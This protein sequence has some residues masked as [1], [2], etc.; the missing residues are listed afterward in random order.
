M[1]VLLSPTLA[2]LA[3]PAA[4]PAA[5][6]ARAKPSPQQDRVSPVRTQAPAAAVLEYLGRYAEA[7]D[8]LDPLGFAED[9]DPP[10]AQPPERH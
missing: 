1:L 10:P 9:A 3:G 8:G 4:A 5:P 6:A 7:A 2:C